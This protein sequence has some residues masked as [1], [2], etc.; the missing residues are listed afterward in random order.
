FAT[1]WVDLVGSPRPA[2]RDGE[3]L[4]FTVREGQC[5]RRAIAFRQGHMAQSLADARRARLAFEPIIN[6]FA[7]RRAVELQVVDIQLPDEAARQG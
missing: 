6:E 1:G 5:V 3:H 2:G 4:Q 7:G